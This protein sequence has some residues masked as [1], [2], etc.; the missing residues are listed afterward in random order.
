MSLSLFMLH[1]QENL[2]DRSIDSPAHHIDLVYSLRREHNSKPTTAY[3][4]LFYVQI[5]DQLQ[6]FHVQ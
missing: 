4:I 3:Q 1:K 6:D 2:F 5:Y